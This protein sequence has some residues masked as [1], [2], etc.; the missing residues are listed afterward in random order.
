MLHQ[1]FLTDNEALSVVG[2][3]TQSFQKNLMYEKGTNKTKKE[4]IQELLSN[5][6][7]SKS[8]QVWTLELIFVTETM[9]HFCPKQ[10]CINIAPLIWDVSSQTAVY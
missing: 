4:I 8:Q 6:P 9:F 2:N 1:L 7:L 5:D 10:Q 3:P